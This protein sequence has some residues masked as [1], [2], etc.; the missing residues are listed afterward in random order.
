MS[1]AGIS[2]V[3]ELIAERAADRAAATP[4]QRPSRRLAQPDDVDQALRAIPPPEYVA[5]LADAEV[6]AHG[7]MVHCPLPDHDDRRPSCMVYAEP[8]RGWYCWGCSRG[9]TAYD[10]AAHVWGLG[11][12]GPVFVELR[13]RLARE[14]LGA[15]R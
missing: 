13:Q 11:L 5:S 2:A 6:P 10:L 7:G 9:G 15:G 14:L 4:R 8:A 1:D 12:R 3:A